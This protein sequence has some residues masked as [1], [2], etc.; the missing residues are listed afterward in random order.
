MQIS[1]RQQ[2]NQN[3]AASVIGYIRRGRLGKVCLERVPG[4]R[5][6]IVLD[7]LSEALWA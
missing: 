1:G 7:E 6:D 5:L 2:G 3:I 4:E